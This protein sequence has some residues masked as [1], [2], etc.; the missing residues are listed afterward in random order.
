MDSESDGQIVMSGSDDSDEVRAPAKKRAKPP[1]AAKSVTARPKAP[2]A[3]AAAPHSPA[4]TAAPQPT[5]DPSAPSAGKPRLKLKLKRGPQA[6]DAPPALARPAGSVQ[7]SYGAA[8]SEEGGVFSD[9][10]G[11]NRESDSDSDGEERVRCIRMHDRCSTQTGHD[12]LT[13]PQQLARTL[14]GAIR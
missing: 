6:A 13:L 8:A 11:S 2:A 12:G 14:A 9:G 5:A 10:G 4:A 1:A 3:A 7:G